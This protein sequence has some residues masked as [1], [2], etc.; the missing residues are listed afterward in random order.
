MRIGYV[1]LAR[2]AEP[3]PDGTVDSVGGD[4]EF[5][6]A[7]S[8][9]AVFPIS[10]IVKLEDVTPEDETSDGKLRMVLDLTKPSGASLLESPFIGFLEPKKVPKG[11]GVTQSGSA[12][13]IM[14]LGPVVFPEPGKYEV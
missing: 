9:P 12:R 3:N 14:N 7:P 5:V 11:L 10:V 6:R 4:F 1:F 8:F 2:Y 13:V